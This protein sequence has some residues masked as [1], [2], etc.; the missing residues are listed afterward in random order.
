MGWFDRLVTKV[1]IALGESLAT[2]LRRRLRAAH[3]WSIAELREGLH[4]RIMG[5]VKILDGATLQSSLTARRCVYYRVEIIQYGSMGDGYG[6]H[7]LGIDRKS[8]PFLLVEHGHHALIDPTFAELLITSTVEETRAESAYSLA[9]EQRAL[10]EKLGMDQVA[11]SRAGQ[12]RFTETIVAIDSTI[13]IAGTAARESDPLAMA[14]R[15]YRDHIQTRS[16]MIG[17]KQ[18]PLLIGDPPP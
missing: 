3:P 14:E 13:A 10:L 7:L 15:G 17:S 5:T 12:I 2:S 18:L 6:Q 9:P 16:R 8:V 1:R 11:L 4:G